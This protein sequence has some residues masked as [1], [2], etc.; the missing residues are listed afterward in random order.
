MLLPLPSE[1]RRAT[2][3]RRSP[4]TLACPHLELL[5]LPLLTD[6]TSGSFH[7]ASGTA[8]LPHPPLPL[9]TPLPLEP[10]LAQ[11]QSTS[12]RVPRGHRPLPPPRRSTSP[13]LPSLRPPPANLLFVQTHPLPPPTS[14][15]SKLTRDPPSDPSRRSSD[16]CSRRDLT[17]R[18][19]STATSR[20]RQLQERKAVSSLPQVTLIPLGE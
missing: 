13:F 2:G 12:V 7:L 10:S 8:P 18:G 3:G 1:S 20:S 14:P 9:A 17:S 5:L 16:P 15:L 6:L 4:S 19:V 11:L